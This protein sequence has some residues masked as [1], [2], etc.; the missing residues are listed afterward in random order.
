L[1]AEEATAGHHRPAGPPELAVQKTAVFRATQEASLPKQ[2]IHG[3]RYIFSLSMGCIYTYLACT[4]PQFPA[5]VPNGEKVHL[6]IL[7]FL[8]GRVS[9]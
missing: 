7:F 5:Q 8:K 2:F 4:K 3:L 6:L 9:L 1:A